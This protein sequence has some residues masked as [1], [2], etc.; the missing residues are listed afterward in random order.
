MWH[1]LASVIRVAF[2]AY[3]VWLIA[4]G[5]ASIVLGIV[6]LLMREAVRED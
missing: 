1:F 4:K 5:G 3:A 6:F 2:L